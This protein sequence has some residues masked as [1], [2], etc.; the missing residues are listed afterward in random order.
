MSVPFLSHNVGFYLILAQHMCCLKRVAVSIIN[1][2]FDH[3]FDSIQDFILI[4]S[5]GPFKRIIKIY[6]MPVMH[7]ASKS[8]NNHRVCG[9]IPVL[10]QDTE[11]QIACVCVICKCL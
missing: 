1:N 11:P 5:G 4:L 8:S 3:R 2:T 7:Y 10:E 6:I 9:S